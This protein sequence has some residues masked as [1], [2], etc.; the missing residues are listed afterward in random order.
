MPDPV[1]I[2]GANGAAKTTFARHF[3]PMPFPNALFLNAD[4]IQAESAKTASALA[5]GR[6]LIRRLDE[7]VAV[8]QDFIVE[9]KLSSKQYARKILAWQKVGYSVTLIFLEVP[10]PDFA[11]ARV[12]SRVAMGGHGIPEDDI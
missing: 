12:E 4:E 6:E 9:T 8:H 7:A 10:G 5:A 1:I 11:V 2:A 3:V